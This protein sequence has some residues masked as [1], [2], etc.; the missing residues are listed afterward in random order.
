MHAGKRV[1]SGVA[2]PVRGFGCAR[3]PWL[4]DADACI[5]KEP[6]QPDLTAD[7]LAAEVV[8]FA[9][10]MPCVFM[11]VAMMIVIVVAFSGRDDA[12]RCKHE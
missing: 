2:Y 1:R 11:I 8:A 7:V 6:A 10:L 5:G 9:A 12:C 4:A 3:G